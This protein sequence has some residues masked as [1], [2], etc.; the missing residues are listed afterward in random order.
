MEK[1]L[2]LIGDIH[3]TLEEF[4]ELL[5]TIQYNPAQMRLILLGDLVDR[6]PYTAGVVK[7]ARELQLESVKG[8]HEDKALRWLY[9]ENRRKSLNIPNPMRS[10]SAKDAAQ[11][12]LLNEEDWNYL[13]SFPLKIDLGLNWWAIHAGV[14]PGISWENQLPNWLMRVRYVNSQGRAVSLNKDKSQPEGS[15]FWTNYYFENR[16]IVYGHVVHNLTQPRVDYSIK[17]TCLGIDTGSV[18]GGYLTAV[19]LHNQVKD[20]PSYNYYSPEFVQVKAKETYFSLK[21]V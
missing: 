14:E 21:N 10:M 15:E 3:G 19:F 13:K 18:F 17:R 1:I 8:N 16:S 12:E 11:L 7:K 20:G 9:H 2:V 4:E 6:G 5:K